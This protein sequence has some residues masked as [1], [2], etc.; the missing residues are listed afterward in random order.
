ML[1]KQLSRLAILS[2]AVVGLSTSAAPAVIGNVYTATNSTDGN[3]INQYLRLPFGHLFSL[4]SVSTGGTG[5][6]GGLGNQG[7]VVLSD[8]GRLDIAYALLNQTTW[9]SWLYSVTQG[10]TT[11]WER[12]DGWTEENGFQAI[13]GCSQRN[14]I[15]CGGR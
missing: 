3:R 15:W 1:S 11:I 5:T 12:W 2:C 7:G 4:G 14:R 10:A 13:L 8:N 9:P 6:G